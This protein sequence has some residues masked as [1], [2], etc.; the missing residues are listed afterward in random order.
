MKIAVASD[1]RV[2]IA[3]HFGRTR[4]F[5]VFD[6]EGNDIKGKHY[7]ENTFNGHSQGQPHHHDHAHHHS[8]HGIMK[9]LSDCEVVISG[10]M[11]RRLLADFEAA[12]KKV[13]ITRAE[14]ADLAITLYLRGKLEHDPEKS[15]Q[16]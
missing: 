16:H 5:L 12:G 9:A 1:N 6:I 15:C 7:V 2:N 8:H 10:G 11:G 3:P 14:E 4:G 13:Y